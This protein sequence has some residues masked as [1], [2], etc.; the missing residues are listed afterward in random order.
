VFYTGTEYK[1]EPVTEGVQIILQY[2]V[3]VTGWNNKEGKEADKGEKRDGEARDSDMYCLMDMDASNLLSSMAEFHKN[4]ELHKGAPPD[5]GDP[6]IMEKIIDII[7]NKLDSGKEEVAFTM[8]Y[9]YRKSSIHA[10]LLKGSDASLYQ[11]LLG[12]FKVKLFPIMLGQNNWD[13]E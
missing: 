4:H 2:D 6:E 3:E 7:K 8:Q 1:V 10:E 13:G 12:H 11:T 5:V 9:P